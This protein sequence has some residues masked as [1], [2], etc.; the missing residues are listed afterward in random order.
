MK[1]SPRTMAVI[2][3]AMGIFFTYIAI[4]SAGDTIWNVTTMVLALFATLEIGVG[5]RLIR[6]H[7]RMKNKKKK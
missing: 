6:L 7:Y 2:Y 4:I 3:F 5:I 1:I